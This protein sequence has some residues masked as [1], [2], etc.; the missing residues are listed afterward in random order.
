MVLLHSPHTHDNWACIYLEPRQSVP[1]C[2]HLG[3]PHYKCW[4]PLRVTN[5]PVGC[6]DNDKLFFPSLITTMWRKAR[7]VT[8]NQ[9]RIAYI[10]GTV[11]LNDIRRLIPPPDHP[12]T[13]PTPISSKVPS[14]LLLLRR[15]PLLNLFPRLHR[16]LLPMLPL[17]HRLHNFRLL[18]QT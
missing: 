5:T 17:L 16:L 12:T 11:T 18:L 4:P 7:V 8:S 14:S 9:G 15:R 3:W 6:K 2:C 13:P 10:S 1:D